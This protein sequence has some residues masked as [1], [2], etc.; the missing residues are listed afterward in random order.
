MRVGET[1]PAGG[2]DITFESL[3]F[4]QD[5]QR[6]SL[7]GTFVAEAPDGTRTT[8]RSEQ[9]S[10]ANQQNVTEVGIDAAI[11]A[12]LYVVMNNADPGQQVATVQFF[13]EPGVLWIWVGML[14]IVLGGVLAAIPRR[15]NMQM[16][17]R[18]DAEPEPDRELVGEGVSA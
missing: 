15:A 12:D 4:E 1:K 17:E 18:R 2:Y 14:I 5:P 11:G 8:I 3:T 10:F 9:V 6:F 7:I 13:V 16:P